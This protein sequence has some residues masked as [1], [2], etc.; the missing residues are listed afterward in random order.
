MKF[1]FSKFFYEQNIRNLDGIEEYLRHD[2]RKE[3]YA[4]LAPAEKLRAEALMQVCTATSQ[5][6]FTS[7]ML[8]EEFFE[9]YQN[10]S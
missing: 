1:E 3:I 7:N 4:K 10:E 5:A 9:G 8:L 2:D 6:N